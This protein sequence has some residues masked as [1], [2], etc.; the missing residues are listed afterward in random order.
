M[1]M[2]DTVK[3]TT[4]EH[5]CEPMSVELKD[6]ATHDDIQAAVDQI[7]KDRE[8]EEP[9]E[10]GDAQKIAEERDQPTGDMTAETNSGSDDTADKGE[11]AGD[12]G[13]RAW[14]DDDL[15]TEVAAYGIDEKELADFTSREELDRKSVV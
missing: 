11:E 5:R 9:K 8:G 13:D 15:K 12:S 14:F 4:H 1:L 10:K 7:V 2:A 6:D 3:P